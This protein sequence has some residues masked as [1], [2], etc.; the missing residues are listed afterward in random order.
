MIFAATNIKNLYL[1]EMAAAIKGIYQKDQ[2]LI[3]NQK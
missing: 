2:A 1:N 3:A